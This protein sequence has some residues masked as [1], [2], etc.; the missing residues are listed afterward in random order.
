MKIIY[1]KHF[2]PKGFGAI[3]LFGLIIV[4]KEY[5]ELNDVEKNHEKIHTRQM[6]ELLIVF[7]YIAYIIEWLIR[8]IQYKDRIKAYRN[9]SYEREAYT[10][11][12]DLNYLE[13]RKLFAF[14]KYFRI[15]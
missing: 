13:K 3:N 14:I 11:M 2:P 8:L 9:I 10:H 5:G 12:Y 7:F 1:N 6:L 4:R 15:I